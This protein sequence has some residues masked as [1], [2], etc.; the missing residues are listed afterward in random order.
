L[1]ATTGPSELFAF[2]ERQKDRDETSLNVLAGCAYVRAE[3]EKKPSRSLVRSVVI[4]QEL[5]HNLQANG[6]VRLGV[7]MAVKKIS[8]TQSS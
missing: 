6:N 8:V 7:E 5:L 1:E 3:I 2:S 4:L